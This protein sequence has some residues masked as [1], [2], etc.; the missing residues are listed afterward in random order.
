MKMRSISGVI[1]KVRQGG[2]VL[3]CA[4]FVAYGIDYEG[5]RTVLGVSTGLSEGE[6]H[7]RGFLDS[8]IARGLHAVQSIMLI[9]KVPVVNFLF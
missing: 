5:K 4:V 8:L 3:D 6:V 2:C 9:R 7:W 1:E